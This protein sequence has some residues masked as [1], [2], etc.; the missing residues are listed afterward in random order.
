MSINEIQVWQAYRKKYGP[1]NDVRRFDRPA[2]LISKI[3]SQSNGGKLQMTDVMPYGKE[4]RAA[5]FED[6]TELFGVK[7]D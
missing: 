1:M 2:A 6:F 7:R 3:I 5:G 4:T